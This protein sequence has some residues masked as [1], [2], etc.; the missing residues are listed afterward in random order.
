MRRDAEQRLVVKTELPTALREG[1]FRLE[2]QPVLD[3]ENRHL[4][5]FEA[6]V[7]WDHP[8][9]GLVPPAD[10]IGAAEESGIIVELGGWVLEEAAAQAARWNAVSEG[11]LSMHVNVSA[12]QLHDGG[13]VDRVQDALSLTGLRPDLLVLELTESVLVE[14]DRIEGVLE[15][16]RALGVGLAVDDFGTGYSSH[17]YLHRFPVTC[18]KID[19]AF[20]AKVHEPDG[21]ALV[22]SIVSIAESLGLDIV[23]EGVETEDQLRALA[24]LR[25]RQA[26]GFHL[27]SPAPAHGYDALVRAEHELSGSP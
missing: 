12:V 18:V 4:S 17:S 23:A 24:D 14:Y 3:V 16:L 25:C 21:A 19:R 22:R 20:V 5:G 10:F 9:R 27:G 1:Q 2:Y 6:L 8:L 15:A 13:L 7:R 11:P 26:Q